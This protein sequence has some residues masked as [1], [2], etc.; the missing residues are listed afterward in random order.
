[1]PGPPPTPLHLKLLRGNPGQRRLRPE[2]EP[3]VEVK[4]PD[5]PSFVTGHAADEW[6][7]VAPELHVLNLLAVLDVMPLAAY[8]MT[9]AR[10][11]T[12]EEVLAGIADRDD[13]H[14]LLIRTA[15]GNPRCNPLVKIAADA[16]RDMLTYAGHFGMTPV[17]RSR[18]AAGVHGQPPSKFGDLLK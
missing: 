18:I 13:T 12:A 15:E 6:W 9:Y 2:P 4:C 7:R 10:W 17:A 8:C 1:M 14:G 3:T 11:R 5:P 16:A